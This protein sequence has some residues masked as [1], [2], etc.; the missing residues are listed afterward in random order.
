MEFAF[1]TKKFTPEELKVLKK[2]LLQ[3]DI[4][5]TELNIRQ[6]TKDIKG[7][8]LDELG[9]QNKS[10]SDKD[11]LINNLQREL[12]EYKINNTET[13]K[14]LAILFPELKDVS[15]GRHITNPNTDSTT[16]L[17]V[18]LYQTESTNQEIDINKLDKWLRQK[19]KTADIKI[20]RQ[21]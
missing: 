18:L 13:I 2:K 15:I 9:K 3:Y 20:V 11:I 21:Q 19:F 14:E 5:N 8:I 10:L 17:T 4:T 1:L 16:I 12:N 6:D 7:E